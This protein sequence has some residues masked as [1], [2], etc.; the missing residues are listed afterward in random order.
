MSIK[1]S[2]NEPIPTNLAE[3]KEGDLAFRTGFAIS[4]CPYPTGNQKRSPHVFLVFKNQ[5]FDLL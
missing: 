4:D 5:L 3:Y 2:L 1:S